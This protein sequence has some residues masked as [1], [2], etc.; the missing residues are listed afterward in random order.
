M[1]RKPAPPKTPKRKRASFST[2]IEEEKPEVKEAAPA[3][4]APE[5]EPVVSKK[6]I[7]AETLEEKVVPE[8]EKPE[9]VVEEVPATHEEEKNEPEEESAPAEEAKEEEKA[10]DQGTTVS[11]F[12]PVE[13]AD[14][15]E[16]AKITKASRS[17]MLILVLVA[18]VS[19]VVGMGITY[20]A[21]QLIGMNTSGGISFMRATPTPEPSATPEPTEKPIDR[22][23]ITIEVLNGSGKAGAAKKAADLLEG[24]GYKIEGTG[25]ADKSTYE[26]SVLEVQDSVD[27]E[28]IALLQKDLEQNYTIASQSGTLSSTDKASVRFIIGK[29]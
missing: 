25:N 4:K 28:I 26:E 19:F 20:A 3:Y 14:D 18:I 13:S 10:D 11:H 22:S 29:K 12:A 7:A 6:E 5:G 1:A 2:V 23:S 27:E 9:M 8:E 21:F 16:F 24:L 15:T 17:S